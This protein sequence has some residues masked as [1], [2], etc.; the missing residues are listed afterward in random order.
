MQGSLSVRH[1]CHLN[2]SREATAEYIRQAGLHTHARMQAIIV[3]RC[4]DSG[5]SRVDLQGRGRYGVCGENGSQVAGGPSTFCVIFSVTAVHICGRSPRS[6]HVWQRCGLES[7]V[8][9][10]TGPCR[11][12]MMSISARN[13][14]G[15]ALFS[16][17]EWARAQGMSALMRVR[18]HISVRT[19]R[20]TSTMLGG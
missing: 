8:C 6:V 5:R 11:L 12:S 13:P 9:R 4:G 16:T 10:A 3:T 1:V 7:P 18:V 20:S 15:L 19:R 2:T 14:W 17:T